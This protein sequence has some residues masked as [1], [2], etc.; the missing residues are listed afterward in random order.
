MGYIAA[1]PY[2]AKRHFLKD[3]TVG[4][5]LS[6]EAFFGGVVADV[7]ADFIQSEELVAFC[8]AIDENP[9]SMLMRK[10]GTPMLSTF[11]N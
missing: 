6:P 2:E 3:L 8:G 11:H 4:Q 9:S 1:R 7:M 5:L 10:V